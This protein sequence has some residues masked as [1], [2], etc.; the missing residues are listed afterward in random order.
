MKQ[1]WYN[2]NMPRTGLNPSEIKEKAI[3]LT[4]ASM[5][6]SGFEKVRLVDIAKE[7]GVSHAA[8]Y[9]HFKDKSALLDAVSERWLM[10]IDKDLEAVCKKSKDPCE[11]ILQW[12]LTLHHA[13]VQKV[14]ND[15]ELYKAFNLSTASEKPFTN[16]HLEIMHAQLTGLVREAIAKKRLRNAD[17]EVMASIIRESTMSF[18]HPRLVAQYLGEKREPLLRQVLESVLKGLKLKS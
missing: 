5:R 16:R 8:L 2:K 6:K 3:D 13:K 12:V 14:S 18:H 15:P 10:Q 11:K 7:L 4:I 17:P 9:A 1:L